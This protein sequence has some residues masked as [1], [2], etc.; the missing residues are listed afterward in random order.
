MKTCYL[1]FF[2]AI[3]FHFAAAAQ[4]Q[5]RAPVYR[6]ERVLV[7]SDAK[8]AQNYLAFPDVLDLGDEVLVAFK[9]GQ[10]H[11]DDVGA[12]IDSIRIDKRQD[13]VMS[14]QILAQV[15]NRIMQMGDWVRYPNGDIGLYVDVQTIDGGRN[16]TGMVGTRSTDGGRTFPKVE[17]VGLIEGVEYGYPFEFIVEGTTTWMLVMTF[18]NLP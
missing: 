7:A 15:D 13:R 5:E 11:A 18:S 12:V 14:S 17:K 16:R 6:N 2:L 4:P 3:G 8:N 10:R 9:R 1:I